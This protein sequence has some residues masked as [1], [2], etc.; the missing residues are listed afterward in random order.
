MLYDENRIDAETIQEMVHR[1]S[2][3]YARATKAV[4]LIPPA[5]YAHWACYRARMYPKADEADLWHGEIHRDIEEA[6]FYI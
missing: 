4:S 3:L 2:Y 5:Y 1:N 6:M